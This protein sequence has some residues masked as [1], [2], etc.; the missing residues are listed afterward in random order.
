M[1]PEHLNAVVFVEPFPGSRAATEQQDAIRPK[2]TLEVDQNLVI[3]CPGNVEKGIKGGNP[4]EVAGSEIQP[5]HI[6]LEKMGLRHIAAGQ[7]KH[8]R[9]D[10]HA[11]DLEAGIYQEADHWHAGPTADVNQLA[12]GGQ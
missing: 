4:I 6:H 7:F 3:L 9:R 2:Q 1:A 11:G 12:A 10:I 8:D 5:P